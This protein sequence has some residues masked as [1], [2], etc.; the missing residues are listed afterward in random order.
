MEIRAPADFLIGSRDPSNNHLA[1]NTFLTRQVD[2]RNNSFSVSEVRPKSAH[3]DDNERG[4]E[5]FE[6]I[7]KKAVRMGGIAHAGVLT[8]VFA[9]AATAPTSSNANDEKGSSPKWNGQYVGLAVGFSHGKTDPNSDVKQEGYF[10]TTDP[11]QVDPQASRNILEN[12]LN[13]SLLWGMNR[14]TGNAM[15]G[16]EAD[17]LLTN[18]NKT[19]RSGDINYLTVPAQTFSVTTKV[20]SNWQVSV[21]PRIGYARK[22]SLFYVSG[23]PAVTQFKYDFTFTDTNGPEFSNISSSNV[24]LGW[25]AGMG[26]EHK[27]KDDWSLK[28]EYLYSYFGNIVKESSNLQ[29]VPADGFDNEVYYSTYNFRIALIKHF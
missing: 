3:D 19:L 9:V 23:G 10:V 18:Y 29:T 15:Y 24:K 6:G 22:T 28:A 7:H 11:D 21:R 8:F 4:N 13:G 17:L 25:T 1:N 27:L 14:Q 20:K 16:V 2:D 5:V 12:N 26:Y